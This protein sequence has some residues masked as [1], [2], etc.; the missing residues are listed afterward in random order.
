MSG[1]GFPNK[2]S[3]ILINKESA[4]KSYIND[5]LYRTLWKNFCVL[6]SRF[7]QWRYNALSRGLLESLSDD[8]MR[9]ACER[10][11]GICHICKLQWKRKNQKSSHGV[12]F[13][14]KTT[15][16]LE[17]IWCQSCAKNIIC[18]F[19]SNF[20]YLHQGD[21]LPPKYLYKC[22]YIVENLYV[23]RTPLTRKYILFLETYFI[24]N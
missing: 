2:C 11:A 1:E 3:K 8:H 4:I 7:L 21:H 20:R 19:F 5:W 6:R 23:Y 15:L 24:L 17:V 10:L 12:T 18:T 22:R 9:I 14:Q 13:R 16:I